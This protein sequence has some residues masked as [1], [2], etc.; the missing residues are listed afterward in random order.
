MK[1]SISH[2]AFLTI[3]FGQNVA[4]PL[5]QLSRW[6]QLDLSLKVRNK[7]L[8]MA[9]PGVE[10]TLPLV[11]VKLSSSRNRRFADT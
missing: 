3:D 9:V 5:M 1:C 6:I 2:F 8:G 7:Q 11:T 10:A 4:R